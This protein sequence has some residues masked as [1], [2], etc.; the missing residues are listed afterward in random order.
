MPTY[1]PPNM[2]WEHLKTK[3]ICKGCNQ[4]LHP[5]WWSRWGFR[6]LDQDLIFLAQEMGLE[7]E[8]VRLLNEMKET[9]RVTMH[10]FPC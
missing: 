2:S 6:D 4:I 10:D 7:E 5:D 9:A 3:N 1:L 8:Q